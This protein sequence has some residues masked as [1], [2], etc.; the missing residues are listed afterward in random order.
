MNDEEAKELFLKIDELKSKKNYADAFEL[1]QNSIKNSNPDDN[2]LLAKLHFENGVV[3]EAFEDPYSALVAY[4]KSF[5]LSQNYDDFNFQGTIQ[6]KM[7]LC[8]SKLGNTED[9]YQ[10]Y[11]K[12]GELFRKHAEKFE[13]IAYFTQANQFYAFSEKMYLFAKNDETRKEVA[14]KSIMMEI[15]YYKDL[16]R[17]ANMFNYSNNNTEA[18]KYA[19]KALIMSMDILQK[20]LNEGFDIEYLVNQILPFFPLTK[21]ALLR[22]EDE[23]TPVIALKIDELYKTFEELTDDIPDSPE[24]IELW[25]STHSESLRFMLPQLSPRFMFLTIDGR[26]FYQTQLG[27]EINRT[28][29]EMD[30]TMFGSVLTAMRYAFQE[31]VSPVRGL[32]NEI[33]VGGDTLAIENSENIIV[34]CITTYVFPEIKKYLEDFTQKLETLYGGRIA[35]WLGFAEGIQDVTEYIENELT[36]T[37]IFN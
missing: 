24:D 28:E 34:V 10:C 25:I 12:S 17:T 22:I 7:G 13:D 11:R 32:I 2:T 37:S 14:Y 36:S 15:E 18:K 21:N 6:L 4:L 9:S 33:K 3:F 27:A 23:F 19:W 35:E 30:T 20:G 31:Q 8:N 1:I 26:L 16:C 29:E 5:D